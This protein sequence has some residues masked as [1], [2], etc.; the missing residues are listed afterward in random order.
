MENGEAKL[1]L[2]G[3]LLWVSH[4]INVTGTRFMCLMLQKKANS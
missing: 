1:A 4:C 3:Y 2:M